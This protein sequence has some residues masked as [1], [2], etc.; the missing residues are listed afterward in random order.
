MQRLGKARGLPSH[1]LGRGP[2]GYDF[3]TSGSFPA[4]WCLLSRGSLGLGGSARPS[5]SLWNIGIDARNK[6]VML[7]T[8]LAAPRFEGAAVFLVGATLLPARTFFGDLA[9]A[10]LAAAL[11]EALVASDF[12][13]A[14]FLAAEALVAVTVFVL[15]A[16]FLVEA[17][18]AADA[19][20]VAVFAGRPF[21]TGFGA[22]ALAGLF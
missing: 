21:V 5:D 6:P 20:V 15:A 7:L 17:D 16:A 14:T 19:F 4:R 12:L 10:V 3:L 1:L 2:L 18:L 13:S 8:F 22:T 11:F 9:A